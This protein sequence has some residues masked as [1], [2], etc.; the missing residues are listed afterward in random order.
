VKLDEA[1]RRPRVAIAGGPRT[2]KTTLALAT[3]H[4]DGRPVIHTDDL[5]EDGF[6]WS[7]ISEEVVRRCRDHERFIVEGTRVAHALRKGLAVDVV[8]YLRAPKAE[9]TSGQDVMAKSIRTVFDEWKRKA[10][11]RVPVV[12]A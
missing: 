2:G 4:A 8:I 1:F 12:Y 3:E 10:G 9:T 11:R 7:E 6:D 5:L